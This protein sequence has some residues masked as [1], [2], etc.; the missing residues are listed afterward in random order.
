MASLSEISE[1]IGAARA[2]VR[3]LRDDVKE[4]RSDVRGVSER[5]SAV[6]DQVRTRRA[7][8]RLIW[9]IVTALGAASWGAIGLIPWRVW[10]AVVK[11]LAAP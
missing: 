11:A 7:R 6:E 9:T 4:M 8:E 10:S 1:K 3:D 2:E 5:L